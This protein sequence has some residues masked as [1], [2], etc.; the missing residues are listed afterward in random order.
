MI[1]L[2]R[3]ALGDLAS[4][5]ARYA[6]VGGHAV[7]VRTEPRFTRGLDLAVAVTNDREAEALVTALGSRGYRIVAI[8]EQEATGRLATVRL[9]HGSA[10][11]VMVDL[12]FATAGIEA[13]VVD[14]ATTVSLAPELALPVASVGHLLALKVLSI[15][16]RT[17]PQ[18]RLDV[19]ALL[20]TATTDDLRI[21]R[22]ALSTIHDRGCDRGRD[23]PTWF[24]RLQRELTP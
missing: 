5:R 1:E 7:S 9:E 15:D 21:A 2:L 22:H 23:L 19:A 12:L 11:G 20:R 14:G 18:D 8:V 16:D 10:P 4:L 24:E 3:R 13:E 6:L 17:R